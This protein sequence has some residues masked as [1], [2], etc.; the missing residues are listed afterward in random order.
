MCVSACRDDRR[1]GGFRACVRQP[2]LLGDLSRQRIECFAK[3]FDVAGRYTVVEA[4]DAGKVGKRLV[5]HAIRGMVRHGGRCQQ[6]QDEYGDAFFLRQCPQTF[7]VQ[8]GGGQ[9]IIGI[10]RA[11]VR[12][13][14]DI[15]RLVVRPVQ[16]FDGL[17]DARIG[18]FFK[19]TARDARC[20]QRIHPGQETCRIPA[21]FQ[22]DVGTRQVFQLRGS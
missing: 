21:L 13:Q 19:I 9:R 3:F 16:G 14:H 4:A 1:R 5:L 6:V 22:I 15:A 11:G 8:T 20:P 18:V 2:Y 10:A 12:D 7:G 17:L